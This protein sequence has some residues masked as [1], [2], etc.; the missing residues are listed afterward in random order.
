M[1]RHTDNQNLILDLHAG[2]TLHDPAGVEANL[3]EVA[4]VVA[5]G[6]FVGVAE[7]VLVGG[8]DGVRAVRRP[9]RG[10]ME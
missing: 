7:L 10:I 4:G 5:T 1:G 2:P 9:T 6:L 8:H 3:H